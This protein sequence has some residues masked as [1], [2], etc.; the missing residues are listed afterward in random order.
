[1]I[2]IAAYCAFLDSFNKKHPSRQHSIL[3]FIEYK[4]EDELKRLGRLAQTEQGVVLDE[5]EQEQDG[6]GDI[7]AIIEESLGVERAA[8]FSRDV[9]LAGARQ[10]ANDTEDPEQHAEGDKDDPINTTPEEIDSPAY[11]LC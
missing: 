3:K 11:S 1:L 2:D 4:L 10:N 5:E 7:L 8:D 9:G 6:E